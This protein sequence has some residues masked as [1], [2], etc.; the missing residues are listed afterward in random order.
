MKSLMTGTLKCAWWTSFG[1]GLLMI[2]RSSPASR[3]HGVGMAKA[4]VDRSC[5]IR[6]D[7]IFMK[8]RVR[9]SLPCIT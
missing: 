1:C 5:W 7:H 6:F 2:K 8:R 4:T 9:R 3:R